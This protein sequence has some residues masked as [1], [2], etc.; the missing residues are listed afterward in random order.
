[1][2][3][4]IDSTTG[5]SFGQGLQ[6]QTPIGG[7]GLGIVTGPH[8]SFANSTIP[9]S[10]TVGT[11]VGTATIVGDYTGTPSWSLSD[12]ADGK[13]AIDS[14]TGAVTVADTL[15]AELDTI[16]ISVSGATP[17]IANSPG[18]ITVT[19]GEDSFFLL[20]N[21]T[22]SFLLANGMDRLILAGPPF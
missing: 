4:L 22:D 12:D 1:M 6:F 19:G 9:D 7:G 21:G 8:I 16:I 3:G 15:T 20:A 18:Y 17:T 10:S 14:S 13:Y 2:S 11:A 5:L